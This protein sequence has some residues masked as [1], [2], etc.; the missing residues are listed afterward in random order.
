MKKIYMSWSQVEKQTNEILR[1]ISLSNWQPDYVVGITRGG[2][3]PATLISQYLN[4]PMHTLKVSLRNMVETESNGWMAEDA[5]GYVPSDERKDSSEIWTAGYRR[6]ILIVDDINDTGATINWI[7][8]DW[9]SGCLP[10]DSVW[11]DIWGNSV[12]FATLYDN[13]TSA[14]TIPISYSAVTIN[15][16]NDPQWIVFP[17]EEFWRHET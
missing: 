6:N 9:E 4:I 8:E 10:K 2:L 16:H 15:K 14:S 17:W 5:F 1:Q 3:I 11:K 13:E 12:K 7:K